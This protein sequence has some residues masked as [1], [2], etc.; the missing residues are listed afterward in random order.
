MFTGKTYE[1]LFE[2]ITYRADIWLDGITIGKTEGTF[3]RNFIDIT[4][5]VKPG[6]T[7]LL[8]LRCRALE[9][10]SEDRP[11]GSVKRAC[12]PR[13][14]ND[15]IHNPFETWVERKNEHVQLAVRDE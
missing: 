14:K 2:G 6:E 8:T 3:K 12:L 15:N 13:E 1:L 5:F 7:H 4:R 11:G 10:S 9:H